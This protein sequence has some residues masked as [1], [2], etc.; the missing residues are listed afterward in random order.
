MAK[1]LCA[2]SGITFTVEHF[3]ISL[4]SRE[5]HHPIFDVPQKRL[6]GYLGKWAAHELTPTD[7]YLLFIALLKSSDHVDFRVSVFRHDLTN[8]I[9]ATH[10]EA[11]ANTVIKLNSV[12]NP[13][14]VF[15]SVVVSP[16]TKGLLNIHHWIEA[17]RKAYQDFIDGYVDYS[18]SVRLVRR[19]AALEKLIKNPFKEPASYANPLA[20]W[21]SEAGHFP[22]SKTEVQGKQV[23]LDE[24]W[25]QIII[26]CSTDIGLFSIQLKDIKE[27]LE[28]CEQTIPI[29]SIF[30]QRLFAT[31]RRAIDRQQSFLGIDK[32]KTTFQILD[33]DDTIEEANISAI[34]QKA[35]MEEP[36][37]PRTYPTKLAFLKAS[38]AWRLAQ[39]H[40]G[41]QT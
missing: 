35:P 23:P 8:S 12:T 32:G 3:P 28:H 41:T 10:M 1:V 33:D 37:D 19:E 6:L 29:G 26:A 20:E 9:V 2:Y 31:L 27:L 25:K 16:E 15:P 4:Q 13:H 11:L 22:E 18:H 14:V 17:W 34:V 36:K 39:K 5:S 30:S 21:A 7:S 24:Y 38:L 40:R